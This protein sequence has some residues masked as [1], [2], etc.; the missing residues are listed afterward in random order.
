MNTVLFDLDGTLLPMDQDIFVNNYL[1]KLGEKFSLLG[2]EPE[3]MIKAIW[4]G[5]KAMIL[6]DGSMSNENRFWETFTQLL[7]DEAR[8]LEPEF[9]NFYRYEFNTIKDMITPNPLAGQGVKI[10]KEKGYS[11]IL[12]TNPLFPKI[13]TMARMEWAG[14]D[15][16]DFILITTYENSSFG[17][18]NLNYYKEI[19]STINKRPEDCLMVG[20]DVIEDMCVNQLGMDSFLLT[21]HIAHSEN[22]DI[23]QYR[24][25]NFIEL[26]EYINHL[27]VLE[28]ENN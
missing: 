19:L 1:K 9:E 21:D 18:P 15:I 4:D 28:T 3:I 5:T 13:A 7:G 23:F 17:K 11:L 16:N 12:A 27:P 24:H 6:N 8:T 26:A 10:L 20:N 22:A 25:G 2:Y 14:L